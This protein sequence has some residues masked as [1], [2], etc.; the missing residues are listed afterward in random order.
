MRCAGRDPVGTRRF[1]RRV[2]AL[3]V[4]LDII[5]AFLVS[6]RFFFRVDLSRNGMYTL[7]AA[8]KSMVSSLPEP[9]SITYYVSDTLRSRSLFPS[10]I[11]DLLNEY[12]TWSGGRVSVISMDP[13]R[14]RQPAN[15]EAL[16]ISARQMQVVDRDQVNLA[17]VYS[18]IV[19][20]YLDRNAALPFVSDLTT[21]EYDLSSQI[22]ALVANRAR[23]IGVLLGDAR[24]SLGQDYRYLQQELGFQFKVQEVQRGAEVPAEI[25]VLFVIGTRDMD[26]ASTFPVDQF[27]MRGGKALFAVDPVDVDLA[28]GLVARVNATT[29]VEDSL[30]AYGARVP[31]QIVLD[32]LN[33]RI[34]FSVQQGR[35]MVVP[36]PAWVSAAARYANSSHPIT[37]RF[38]GLDLYW[39]A[40]VE[41]IQRD[42]VRAEVL[43]R[44]SPNSWVMKEPFETNPVILQTMKGPTEGSTAQSALALALT[45]TFHSGYAGRTVPVRAGERAP[46]TPAVEESPPTRIIVVGNAAFASDIVQYT[47]ASYNMSFLSNCAEWL[48][49]EDDLLAIKTRAQADTRLDA[50]ADPAAKA[51]A[52][53]RSIA[54]NVAIVPVAV[55]AVGIV[56]L[57]R[58]RRR[59]HESSG[60]SA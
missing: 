28:S 33:Q 15:V 42:G 39:A 6:S 46:K 45:G 9:L 2:V 56:R 7:S 60:E 21:L 41:A 44:T 36:Y 58:R 31:P 48:A 13:S 17:T 30:A 40:P 27:I 37:A 4:A 12:A 10:Q 20:R 1:Q 22:R 52:M 49:Q 3:L 29:A 47:Q 43:A 5:L 54:V 35:Y 32:T 25:S 57:L 50:L 53:R 16:G 34:S 55:I 14:S 8:S 59:T 19:L 51:A 24:K 11:E 23:I 38:G 18:G 26:D